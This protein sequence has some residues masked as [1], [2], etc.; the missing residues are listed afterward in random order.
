MVEQFSVPWNPVAVGFVSRIFTLS[1]AVS[2]GDGTSADL[3]LVRTS[4]SNVSPCCGHAMAVR[5]VGGNSTIN[6]SI[7]R[8]GWY[9]STRSVWFSANKHPNIRL[10]DERSILEE[11]VP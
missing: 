6:V 2:T 4:S 5:C 1:C 7:N 3:M 11:F 9:S 8:Y 10:R